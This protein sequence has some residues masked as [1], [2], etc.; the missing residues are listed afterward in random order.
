MEDFLPAILLVVGLG[1]AN[2]MGYRLRRERLLKWVKPLLVLWILLGP[3]VY[4]TSPDEGSTL[5]ALALF[6]RVMLFGWGL[7]VL[8]IWLFRKY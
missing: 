1:M 8:F 4:L 2:L 7:G 3:I 5:F 6:L